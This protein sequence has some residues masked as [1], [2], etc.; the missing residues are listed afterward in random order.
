[1]VFFSAWQR[2]EV[3]ESFGLAAYALNTFCDSFEYGKRVVRYDSIL[4]AAT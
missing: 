4:W 1:M 2:N 3:H